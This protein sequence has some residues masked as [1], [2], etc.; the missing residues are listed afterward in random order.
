MYLRS[1]WRRDDLEGLDGSLSELLLQKWSSSW[2]FTSASKGR[3]F[4]EGFAILMSLTF[5]CW[6]SSVSCRSSGASCV[7]LGASATQ[8]ADRYFDRI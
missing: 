2:L 7:T 4:Y 8:M 1:S 3:S 6:S 5:S